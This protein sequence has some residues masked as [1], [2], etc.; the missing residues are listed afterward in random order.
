LNPSG[1]TKGPNKWMQKPRIFIKYVV[2]KF[3]GYHLI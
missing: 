2:F 1:V 3:L